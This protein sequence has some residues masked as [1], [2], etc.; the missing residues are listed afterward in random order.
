MR[1]RRGFGSREFFI[2]G[3]G[4]E[5]TCKAS[6]GKVRVRKRNEKEEK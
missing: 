4:M 6:G 5:S 3:R 2:W 1:D